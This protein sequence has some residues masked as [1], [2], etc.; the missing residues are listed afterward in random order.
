MLDS[1][2]A[3]LPVKMQ[4]YAKATVATLLAILVVVAASIEDVPLWVTIVVAVLSP[5]AV[6]ATPNRGY[7]AKPIQP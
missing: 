5:V 7:K 2:V 1:V 3:S 6:H 4:P